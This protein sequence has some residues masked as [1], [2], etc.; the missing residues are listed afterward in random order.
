[1]KLEFIP[2]KT[3]MR[4]ALRLA[5]EARLDGEIPVGA[6]IVK[7]GNILA[8]GRNR[9]ERQQSSLGHAELDAISAACRQTGS[10]RLEGCEIYVTLEPCPMCMGAILNARISQVVYG[11]DDQAAGSCGSALS[12]GELN[13]YKQPGIYPGFMEE[14][15]REQL[16]DF[17]K[18]L[19]NKTK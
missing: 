19:R 18:E 12:M 11:L 1:M 8:K 10:W 7:D 17:F 5:E 6:V 2:V 14:E 4:E 13:A 3:Y 16:Q 9:R 15:C